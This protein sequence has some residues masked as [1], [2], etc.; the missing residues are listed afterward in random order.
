MRSAFGATGQKCSAC[1]RVYVSR[2]VR[3]RFVE[4]LVEKTKQ[5]KVGIPLDRDVWMGPLINERALKNYEN[6]IERAKRDGGRILV[7]GRRIMDEPFNHG[8]FVEPTVIDG[9]PPGHALFK[10]ELFVPITVVADVLTLDEA[11]EPG[12]RHR[13]RPDGGDLLAGR[14]GDRRVLRADPGGRD[15]RQPPR[16][17]DDRGVARA[18]LVRRLEGER[19]DRPGHGRPAL[20]AAV[21]PRAEPDAGAVRSGWLSGS[22]GSGSGEWTGDARWQRRTRWLGDAGWSARR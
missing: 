15:L 22:D 18:E 8:Y 13:V 16:R 9:L 17:R 2:E 21:L 12:Q 1:S 6:A 5:I 7:G 19:L 20:P 14:R 3:D 10:E 11:I 4:Q